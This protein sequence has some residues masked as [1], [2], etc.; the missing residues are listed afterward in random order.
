VGPTKGTS[1]A[2]KVQGIS[3]DTSPVN[4]ME[5]ASHDIPRV[6]RGDLDGPRLWD[7]PL[8]PPLRSPIK[9]G[10]DLTRRR[11]CPEEYYRP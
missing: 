3:L 10:P 8:R 5:K 11:S 6:L 4:E 7:G 1:R 9:G 2:D